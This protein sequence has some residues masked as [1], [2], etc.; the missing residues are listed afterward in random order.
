MNGEQRQLELR[1]RSPSFLTG[2]NK[3]IA[4]QRGIYADAHFRFHDVLR[5]CPVIVMSGYGWGDTAIN[6]RFD[7]WLDQNRRNTIVLLHRRPEE[8]A[9][10]SV[11]VE[12]AYDYWIR[13]RHLLPV[14]KWLSEVSMSDIDELL[15]Q[16]SR[17]SAR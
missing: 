1:L 4:Y 16:A 2:V 11:I 7:T 9:K 17:D 10:R 8:I 6:W 5:Q 14:P 13:S 12:S 3:A 15:R